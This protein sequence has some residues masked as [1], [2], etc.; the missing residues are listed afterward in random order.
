MNIS[1]DASTASAMTE[2]K[3]PFSKQGIDNVTFFIRKNIFDDSI[4]EY[5]SRVYFKNGN[6]SGSQ[7]IKA[8]N[9]NELLSKTKSF[10]DSLK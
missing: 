5:S 4:I 1:L 9:F 8:Q 7:E 3:D 6:T 2:F 10:V